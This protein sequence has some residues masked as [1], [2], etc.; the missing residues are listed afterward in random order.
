MEGRLN[1][2]HLTRAAIYKRVSTSQQIDGISLQL[3]DER[4]RAYA[5]AQGWDVAAEYEDA[6]LSGGNTDRPAYQRM[7]ADAKARKFDVILVYKLDRLTRSVR[8]F[9][10]LAD[11]L[12]RLGIAVVAVTQNIDTSSPTVRLLRNILIDFAN[13]ERELI[14]ERSMDAKRR[15]TAD[16]KYLG[17]RPPFGYRKVGERGSSRLEVVPEEAAV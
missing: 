15:Q 14:A 5:T 13:F 17:W 3:Q 8:D 4:L 7:M 12:D 11:K 6:G 16:G 9:H 1:M 10:E 2:T